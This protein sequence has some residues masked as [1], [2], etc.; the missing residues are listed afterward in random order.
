ML[1]QFL[2]LAALAHAAP[3]AP[4]TWLSP[5][6][7]AINP[8][9]EGRLVYSDSMPLGNGAFTAAAWANVTSGGVSIL[10]G[11]QNAQSSHTELFKLGL[12]TLSLSPSPFASGPFFSQTLDAATATVTVLAGGTDAASAAASLRIYIDANA[13]QL[14]VD[15]S[16]PSGAA[17]SLAATLASTRPAT[18]W[19]YTPPFGLCSAVSSQ[20]D[21]FVDPLPAPAP[22]ARP[23]P[24]SAADAVRRPSARRA[25]TRTLGSLPP[26]AAFSPATLISYHRNS[27]ADLVLGASNINMTLTQQGLPQLIA[28][29]PDHWTDLTFGLALDGGASPAAPLS[30]ASPSLLVSAAPAPAFSLRATALALQTDSA[31]GWL[32][33]LGAA[34]AAAAPAP[35]AAHE[36]WWAA[37]WARSYI[38]V[39][40]NNFTAPAGLAPPAWPAAPAAA[41]LP[42]AG[43]TLWLRAASLA[44]TPNGSTVAAWPDEAAS[45]APIAQ[46]T[47]ALRPVYLADAFGAGAAGVAFDG[48]STFLEGPTALDAGRGATIFAVARDD[49]SSGGTSAC[50]SGIVYFKGSCAGISTVPAEAGADDDGSG[51]AAPG[52]P[53][54]AMLDW[55]GSNTLGH[56]N[57]RGRPAVLTTV[58]SGAGGRSTLYVDACAEASTAQA[59]GASTEVQIGTRNDELG[60]FFKGV[61]GEVVVFPYALNASELAAMHDYLLGAWPVPALKACSPS[62]KKLSMAVEQKYALTRYVQAVQSRNTLWPEKFNGMAFTAFAGT[63]GE[64]EYR[65]WGPAN[66]C[67]CLAAVPAYCQAQ[68]ALAVPTHT[69]HTPSLPPHCLQGKT[70]ACPMATCSQRGTLTRC[71]WFWT[72]TQT[73]QPFWRPAFRP[74]LGTLACGPQRRTCCMGPTP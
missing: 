17:F 13:D 32:T 74:T 36:A 24:L 64:A 19:T 45:G 51:A 34:V 44:G 28:S 59:V 49:G 35:R 68:A 69:A 43:A 4:L 11:H 48:A 41:A 57:L 55:A 25:P 70:L 56:T 46:P 10:L 15:I 38:N 9:D 2:A 52:T 18:P 71:A 6:S 72:T 8:S 14:L 33:E 40:V 3:P 62:N 65:G 30:R 22:L 20:P 29:T 39:T 37:F 73:W 42:V 47:P 12:L 1:T 27:P 7:P 66:W 50:C 5:S 31:T 53:M 23:A 61:V 16:S 58:Y 21:V 67:A 54:V 26:T 63:S 60:R